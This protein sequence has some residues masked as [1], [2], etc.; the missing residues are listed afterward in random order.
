MKYILLFVCLSANLVYG[1]YQLGLNLE[2]GK[3]YYHHTNQTMTIHREANGHPMTVNTTI[4]TVVSYT[5]LSKSDSYYE[6]SAAFDQIGMVI[7]TPNGDLTFGSER[8]E[9]PNDIL[10]MVFKKMTKQ[11]FALT[12]QSNGKIKEIKGLDSLFSNMLS[13]FPGLPEA[14]KTKLLSQLKQATGLMNMKAG[15]ELI[16]GIFP[17]Q[18]VNLNQE[19]ENTTQI[20]P[21]MKA[22]VT[23]HFKLIDYNSREAVIQD[24]AETNANDS[25]PQ[26]KGL[27]AKFQLNGTTDSKIKI[28]SKTGWIIDADITQNLK[29]KVDLKD[30]P[31]VPGGMSAPIELL[32]V[33]KMT[34]K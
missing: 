32:I 14:K 11:S 7:K 13:D 17:N 21:L 1:Q 3:T 18:K 16:T 23:N 22:T 8:P 12:L 19:W 28:D 20:S 30:N 34:D 29:G 15:L 27:R 25:V 31:K 5:V 10:S 26:F 33:S 4:S 9:D 24:H 2:K 6:L